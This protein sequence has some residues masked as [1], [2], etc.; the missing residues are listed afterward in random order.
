MALCLRALRPKSFM[1]YKKEPQWL[2]RLH[3]LLFLLHTIYFVPISQEVNTWD[4]NCKFATLDENIAIVCEFLKDTLHMSLTGP[5]DRDA[6]VKILPNR[7]HV[8]R[9]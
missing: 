3:K 7:Q 2:P 1:M 9:L 4:G 8:G 6:R 5:D